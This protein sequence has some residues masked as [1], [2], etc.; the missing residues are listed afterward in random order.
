MAPAATSPVMA[1]GAFLSFDR[2][3]CLYL[4]DLAFRL[5]GHCPMVVVNEAADRHLLPGVSLKAPVLTVPPLVQDVYPR[6]EAAGGRRLPA[7]ERCLADNP[8]LVRAA[9]IF[10]ATWNHL[11]RKTA[12]YYVYVYYKYMVRLLDVHR[13][14]VLMLWNKFAAF[15]YLLDQE[16]RRRCLRVV[17]MEYGPLPGSLAFDTLGQT[18]ESFPAAERSRFNS[19]KISSSDLEIMQ[20]HL[21]WLRLTRFSRR[22]QPPPMSAETFERGLKP[23]RP[24]IFY[25]GQNDP[26][27][28]LVPYDELARDSHSPAF[29]SSLEALSALDRL[30][31]R[32]DWNLIYKPHPIVVFKRSQP[33]DNLALKRAVVIEKGPIKDFIDRADLLVTISSKSAYDALIHHKPVVTMGYTPL[34]ASGAV[35]EVFGSDRLEPVLKKALRCGLTPGQKRAFIRHAARMARHYLYADEAQGGLT[36]YAKTI[37]DLADLVLEEVRVSA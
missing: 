13:P 1:V 16:A 27:A 23:G 21:Q 2:R 12:E 3:V 24:V 17:Y 18:G 10:L 37:D 36:V 22:R 4:E 32:Q 9:D 28:G 30:A 25:A 6:N 19:L 7:L 8:F 35:Y 34:R 15:H 14:R 20:G 11:T 33:L 5:S 29:A 31:E 26:D